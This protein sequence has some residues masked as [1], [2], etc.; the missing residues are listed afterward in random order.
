MSEDVARWLGFRGEQTTSGV[1]IECKC[2]HLIGGKCGI[3]ESR[4]EVCKRFEVGSDECITAIHRRRPHKVDAILQL[5][6]RTGKE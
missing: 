3:Y 2:K 5:I 1:V 4:P 6:A